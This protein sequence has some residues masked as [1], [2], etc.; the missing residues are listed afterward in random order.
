MKVPLFFY[1]KKSYLFDVDTLGIHPLEEL[2][3]SRRI[4]TSNQV[5]SSVTQS[6]SQPPSVISELVFLISQSCNMNCSYCYATSINRANHLMSFDLFQRLVDY[7]YNHPKFQVTRIIFLG[8]EP[9]INSSVLIRA[10]KYLRETKGFNGL[11]GIVTNGTLVG[12]REIS[13]LVK[14]DVN[15]TVSLDGPQY[16]HDKLRPDLFGDGSY[17]RAI[18]CIERLTEAGVPVGIEGTYTSEH[19]A[20]DL[21][22]KQLIKFYE[23]IGVKN[24]YIGPDTNFSKSY[25]SSTQMVYSHLVDYWR[26]GVS[27]AL[28]TLLNNNPVYFKTVMSYIESIFLKKRQFQFC[29]A[30]TDTITFYADGRVFPCYFCEFGNLTIAQLNGQNAGLDEWFNQN[31]RI[32]SKQNSECLNC[33]IYPICTSCAGLL[34]FKNERYLPLA[35]FCD[36]HKVTV[37]EVIHFII[38]VQVDGKLGK[39]RK[40]LQELFDRY[41]VKPA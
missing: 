12:F 27:Y 14:Y 19:I 34:E 13:E 32:L 24:I 5:V 17:Q 36:I 1:K 10:I 20:F 23:S 37:E 35:P 21:T 3:V 25:G 16:I 26:E 30:G 29:K 9:F 22:L 6:F 39:V 2:E 33:W 11:I 40:N 7:V 18:N 8:G 38:K 31:R 28:N 4:F 15:V 41:R